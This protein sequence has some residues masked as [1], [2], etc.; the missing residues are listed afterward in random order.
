MADHHPEL[1][2]RRSGGP[3]PWTANVC[4]CSNPEDAPGCPPG[5]CALCGGPRPWTQRT[6]FE[7]YRDA[8]EATE[9]LESLQPTVD[10]L[11]RERAIAAGTIA[12][13]CTY[14][15]QHWPGMMPSHTASPRCQSGRR[16]HCTCDTCF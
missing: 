14:C 7:D 3:R 13:G 11:H 6:L 4:R 2:P 8:R 12:E 1:E 15:E 9:L 16:N 10:A 5:R